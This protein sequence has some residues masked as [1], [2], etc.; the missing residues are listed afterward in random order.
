MREG[1]K[2]DVRAGGK[3]DVRVG[4]MGDVRVGGKGEEGRMRKEGKFLAHMYPVVSSV[5]RG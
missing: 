4:G 5:G 2:G 3:G 1:G